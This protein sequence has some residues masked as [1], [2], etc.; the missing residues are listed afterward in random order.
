MIAMPAQDQDMVV[1]GIDCT[2]VLNTH[3]EWTPEFAVHLADGRSGR[4]ACP[5]ADTPSVYEKGADRRAVTARHVLAEARSALCGRPFGQTSFD[6]ALEAYRPRWGHAA[7][8]GLSAA[9]FE[10]RRPGPGSGGPGM[11]RL[12]FNLLN[13]GL[14][15]YSLPV[16]ADFTEFLLVPR[17][18]AMVP[19]IDAY[20]R[21]L[22]AARTAL[23][24]LPTRDVGGHRVHEVGP[25]PNKAA[26]ALVTA[27]LQQTGLGDDFGLMVDASAGDWLHGDKYVLPVSGR[28]FDRD[29]L[30]GYWLELIDTFDLVMVEDPLAETD[31]AGWSALRAARPPHCRLLGDNITSTCPERLPALAHCVDGVL[32]KPDQAGS[33]SEARRFA[34]LAGRLGLPLIA[35]ARSAETDSPLISH[36]AVEFGAEYLK[37]GPF[38]DF[39]SV[40]RTNELLRGAMR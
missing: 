29:G 8:Y 30:I 38:A 17:G 26:L 2:T 23:A 15:A 19:A 6:Q 14:H 18:T 34:R 24:D 5:R 1:D 35:S 28:R 27:L 40:L 31:R 37:V 12:L 11:P 3:L 9:H 33:L 20:R 32:L 4:A 13:G 7:C 36:V 10:A 21:L 22:P 16:A 25:E 39:S